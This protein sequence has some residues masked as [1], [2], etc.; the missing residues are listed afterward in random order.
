MEEAPMTG[1]PRPARLLPVLALLPLLLAAA[2]GPREAQHPGKQSREVTLLPN[3]WRISPAG[4]HLTVG[5]L[6][7]AMQE[8]ADGR[9]V[10]VSSNG[11]MKPTLTVIDVR[12]FYVKSKLTVDHAWLGLAWSPDGR[13]LYSS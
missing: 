11:W 1:S 4:R 5:D 3:G 2:Q 13:R 7:L 9:Y 10:I 8:S 6:P 12:N